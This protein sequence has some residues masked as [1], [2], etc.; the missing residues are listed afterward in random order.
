V[1]QCCSYR[2]LDRFLVTERLHEQNKRRGRVMKDDND[3]QK[4]PMTMTTRER[5]AL[6]SSLL[7]IVV[8]VVYWGIQI[9]GV[10][11]MLEMA[12]G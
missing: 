9:D 4:K 5:V 10:M 12:Y 7:I 2:A 11:E 8:V 6:G 3:M 1:V